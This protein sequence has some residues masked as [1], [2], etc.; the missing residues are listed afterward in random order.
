MTKFFSNEKN[1]KYACFIQKG[2]LLNQ[3]LNSREEKNGREKLSM[4]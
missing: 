2:S 3:I 4:T 1:T